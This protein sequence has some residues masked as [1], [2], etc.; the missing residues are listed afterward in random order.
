MEVIIAVVFT[1]VILKALLVDSV[2]KDNLETRQTGMILAI[3]FTILVG[4]FASFMK[5]SVGA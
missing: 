1:F 2:N 5:H 3:T 4:A